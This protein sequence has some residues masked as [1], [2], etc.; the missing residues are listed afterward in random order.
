M[1]TPKRPIL[2]LL[3]L[4]GACGLSAAAALAAGSQTPVSA[5]APVPASLSLSA[6]SPFGPPASTAGGPAAAAQAYELAGSSVSDG[7]TSVCIFE[8]G[9]KRSRWI[10]VGETVDGIK[11]VSYDPLR[12]IVV[13]TAHGTRRE[14]GLRKAVV[15]SVSHPV[16]PSPLYQTL[17]GPRASPTADAS[18]GGPPPQV[19]PPAAPGTPEHEATEARMLV[20]DLLEI[21]IQQ[22]KAYEEARQKAAAQPPAIT[23][24]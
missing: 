5:Q 22:R 21:G 17:S 12:D 3:A 7:L 11:V 23:P 19:V 1:H 24:N 14:L 13:I 8:T 20:S 18:S 6:A 15:A 4:S 2:R 9:A 10:P 16:A